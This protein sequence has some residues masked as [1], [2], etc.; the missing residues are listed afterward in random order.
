MILTINVMYVDNHQ[1]IIKE[2]IGRKV[3]GCAVTLCQSTKH[4]VT[5]IV[6]SFLKLVRIPWGHEVGIAEQERKK[7]P[8]MV[9]K[10]Y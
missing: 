2:E 10:E 1:S 4:L 3:N 8:I 7:I 5:I 9:N 6:S